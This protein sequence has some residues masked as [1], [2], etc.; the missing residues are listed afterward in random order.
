[1][2]SLVDKAILSGADNRPPMLEKDMYDSWKSR[3][4][5]YMLNRQHGRM[6]L[7]SVEHAEAIQADCDVKATNI[8]LQVLPLEVYALV[9]TKFLNTLPPEWSKFV[10]NVKLLLLQGILPLTT[11]SEP[12]PTLVSKQ[13]SIMEG[14]LSNQY[15][16]GRILCRLCTKPKRKRV[17]EWFKDK[18]LLV[19][20][21]ANGQV[22][23]EE[24]LEFLADSGTAESLSN[25]KVITTNAAYQA[26][27]LDAYDSD[28]DELNSAKISLMA[29][30][31]H[32]GSDNLA[33]TELS[34]EQAFWS[35]YLV[36]TDEPNLSA[37]TTI[38]EVPKE[39]PKVSMVNSC[40]KKLKFHLASFDM[41]VK[42]RTT[43]TA[44]TEG[45]GD[46][47]ERKV[48][49]EV[50]EIET[51]N[52]K[53]D[54]KKFLGT[55]KFGNDHVAKIMGYGDYQ[56][57]NVTIS[58]V[59]LKVPV[60]RI[61]NDNGTEFFNQTLRDYYEEVDISHETLV[62]RSPQQNGVVERHNRTL[63]EAACTVLIYAQA[64]LFLWAEVVATACF[65]QNR[66]IIRLRHGKT[67]YKLLQSKLPDLSF[68]H[69]FGALCYPKN[70]SENLGKLQP[71]ADIG[72]FIG[73]A[74]TKKAFRIYN[75]CTRRIVETIHVDFDELTTMASEQ[76]SL[77]PALNEMTPGTITPEVI[78]PIV[79]V[80]PPVHAD[81]TSSPSSTTVDQD[82]PSPSKSHTTTEIQSSVILQDVGD[83]NLD[84]EAA[85]IGNDPLFGVPIQEVTSA[86]S[87]STASPQLIVQTNHP[88]P[89]HNS[90]WTKD[91]PLNNIIGQL[92]RPVSTWLQLYEQTLFCYYDAFLT[93]VE[94]K[95]YK[96]ALTQ[97]CWIKAIQ[98]ELNE[99]ERLEVWELVPHPDK[100]MVINLKWIYKVK[101]DELGG[102]LKN[103]AR[104]VAR[105]YR[106]EEGIDF[107]ESFA[108]VARLEAI[109]IFLAYAAHKNMIVYQMNVNTVFLN[110]NL[111]EEVYV[112]Q[113]DG[114]VD[115]DNPNHVYKLKKV[116]YGLKQAP[117]AWYDMLSSFLLSQDFSKGLVDLTLFI[118][119]NG[120]DLLLVQIYFDDIIFAAS[121]LELCDLFAYLMCS[122]F[123]MSMMG[124]IL[125]FLGLQISQSP[126]GIFINQSKYAF[127]SLKK[128]GFES[129]EPV[130]TPMVE[131][132]K[133]DEDREGKA[134]DPSHYRGMI[135]T[136][137]YLTAS[138]SDLQFTI[139]MCA[140]YQARPI[141]KHLLQMRI[142]LV[143]K[144][145]AEV[146]LEVCNFWERGLL[147]GRQRGKRVLLFPIWKLNTSPYLD[148]VLKSYGY[149]HNFRIMAL[150]LTKFQYTAIIKVLLPYAA[151][152]SKTLGLNTSTSDIISSKSRTMAT[153]IKQQVAMDKALVPSTQRC[154]FFK[155]FLVTTDVPEIYMQEFWATAYVHQH[156][157]RFKMNNKKHIVSLESFRKMLHICP[158]IH[159]QSFD[160]LPFEE[161]ILDFIRD[162]F[163]FS[164]IKVVSRHQNT[165]QYGAMLPI[166]LTNDEIKNTKAY[167][168]YYDF[169]TGKA[170]PKPKASARRKRSGFDTSIT[171]P[172]ATVTPKPTVAATPRLTATAKGKQPAKATKAKSPS[173]LLEVQMKELVLGVTDVPTDESDEELSWNSS[174]DEGA[175]DQGKDGDD[176]EGDKG[177]ESD[178]GEEDVDED[179]DGDERYDDKENQEV[180]KYDEQDDAEGG[181]DDKGEGKSDEEDDNKETRDEESFDPI[182]KTSESSED[183]G[184]GEEDQGLNVNEEEH[185]K[186]DEE[187]KLYIDVNINQERGLPATLEVED[188][189]VTLT[190]VNPDGQQESSLVSSQF[191]TSML[192][193]TS[194]VRMESIFATASSSVAP[195]PT[196]TPIMTPSTIATITT[197]SQAPIPLMPIPSEVIQNLPTFSLVFR[198][199]DRLK[200]LEANFSEFRQ[201]Y[202]FAEAVSTIP[203]E[204][205]NLYKALVDAYE[206][207]KIILDSYGET[208]ILK[209]RRDDDDDK[210]EGPSARSDRGS[211]RRRE[212]AKDQPIV[213]SSQHPEWFSQ[214]QKPPTLDRDWN[215]TLPAVQGS[216]QTWISKLAKQADYC[217]S[218]NE[219]L[220]TSLDFSNFIMNW[221]RVDTLTLELLAG[222]TYEL[223][224][225][226]C[227]SLIELEY[228]LEEVYKATTDQLDWVN[229]K[230]Q[231]YPHNLLQPLPLIPDNRGRRVI[232]FAHFINNDLEY[233][234]GGA[235]SLKYTTSVTKMKAADYEH[236]KWIE[237][238]VPSTMWIQEPIDYDK[239]T[240]W[241]VSHWGCKRDF[242]RL[243]LQDI[244][245]TLLLLV[246]GK[247]Y[248]LTVEERFASNVSLRM[249][250][251]SIVIQ[252]RV[253]DLQ[254]GVE[255]Y[256]KRLNL[257]KP[258]TYRSDLKR[259]EAYT[260]Y[261]NARGFIYQNKDKKNRLMRI[262]ELYK[263]SN[264]TLNDVHAALDDRL[265]GI[266]MQYLP[267]T[268]W[269][270]GDKDRAATMIQAIDKMLKTKRIMGSL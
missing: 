259:R 188:S 65:T 25:Q 120:D 18:V 130:D 94:P 124:K 75:R 165:Q 202:P 133:L 118:R 171:P 176:D 219:L 160:K 201:T 148:V 30:L 181:G 68:F 170:A 23:Q 166:K 132:S 196:S 135:G 218:F 214:S 125:F 131:K 182:P 177:D 111:R 144:I 61:R 159:G 67:P 257:T 204:Q 143:A 173:A 84:M 237:D 43:A 17:A 236:I 199:D 185:V 210:D 252:R 62:A 127:E 116:L 175:D 54:H 13:L 197:I 86:Q 262:D 164:M 267:Q 55:V 139:Y 151:I 27:D 261:S 78:A 152:M 221:L 5:F 53:L 91:H 104:L 180:A 66:S 195:L 112:S 74:P 77:G 19:Q 9:N 256:Q 178:E 79:E 57:G 244:E 41:V 110:G 208:V 31:S 107:E 7:E 260:T 64:P 44:I 238:L 269:R 266:R 34:E 22:L 161:E 121:T 140:R 230:G 145:L 83:D 106:H 179:K 32:Y 270:K 192:N 137:L 243:R 215:K 225:G 129:C 38:V 174:D 249:F 10:T 146:H 206:A 231:Q 103:K 69:V 217:S 239:H 90:K 158:R 88:V 95:T 46:V 153:T 255:S 212:G 203:D 224:K 207:D 52:I 157:I 63:I 76:S 235:S 251:R 105:S 2:T 36:Q 155:A 8:I 35:Q 150:D 21:Q 134:V 186:E 1:M 96:D 56:I 3:M 265:K 220:D 156:S 205:R 114:F 108:L 211:K 183:E 119:R 149:D 268:I 122:K 245:D 264:E 242:K 253:K 109:W 258:D 194:D 193:P 28:C 187:D 51:L 184:D 16:G 42:E 142:M 85:H 39:L 48:K 115:P 11:G 70:D 72:I 189:H 97:S 102:I 247:L 138:R 92:S 228:H 226:S 81:S 250:T 241:G 169:A 167:K 98:E 254:L 229:P 200:S 50:E 73:Y 113:L 82:A 49:R 37:S 4:E 26:D 89:H 40:L 190:P 162:D 154:P 80:I 222:P 15:R 136:L 163:L 128:Y 93:S 216:T 47:N 71:K 209:R 233:L 227:K 123:K 117:R 33:E 168:E 14:L 60:H 147:G 6:I 20:A 213:Q 45:T 198:F 240:L 126:R 172:T 24:E 100:V 99:S 58:Q 12:R 232:P 234:R 59:R 223:M 191:V 29:K 246:Q 263:F 141:E 248:N 87:S 101:L